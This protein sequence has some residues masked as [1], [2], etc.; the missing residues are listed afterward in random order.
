M[1]NARQ[2]NVGW[3]IDYFF[4]NE[5]FVPHLKRAFIL[6]EIQ[7][8]FIRKLITPVK[9]SISINRVNSVFSI[10]TYGSTYSIAII[11]VSNLSC[12]IFIGNLP[13]R[14]TPVDFY[15]F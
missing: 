15:F 3:R 13:N 5:K 4:V 9:G 12:I 7:V 6:P 10:I 11:K 2:K 14:T 1:F 8:T